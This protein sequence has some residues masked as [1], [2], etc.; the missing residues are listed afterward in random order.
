[1][2]PSEKGWVNN[3]VKYLVEL[4]KSH[5]Y[6]KTAIG[7]FGHLQADEKLYKL[8]QPSGL[9]YGHPIQAPGNYA[10]P[11]SRWE[12]SEKMK[13]ILLDSL[14]NHAVLLRA[15]EIQ[16]DSDFADCLHDSIKEIAQFYEAN[17]L[18]NNKKR[19]SF[20][21]K[22]KKSENE[23]VE[24][25]VTKRLHVNSIWNS[26]F[27]SGFFQNS[28]LFLDVY[29][30]GL[31]L[32]RKDI[33]VDFESFHAHQEKLRMNLL[34]MIAAAAHAN[35]IIEDEE[36]AL[37]TFFIQSARLSK[38]N[39]RRAMNF[40]KTTVNLE[41]IQF[42]TDDPWIIRKYMLE[43]AILTVWA[44]RKVEDNE[45]EFVRLL[46]EK[47][48]FSK[49][50][51]DGSMLA[52]ESFIISNWEQVHFLQKKH[53]LLIIKD[54]FTKRFSEIA[55]KNKKAFVQ[56]IKESKELMNLMH[57]MTREKLSDT[58]KN[59]VRAQL[60]DVLKTLPALVIIALPGT[61]MT[62][63]LLLKLLPKSAF[64]SAFSEID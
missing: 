11:M 25:I 28:L 41:N 60:L 57:K 18:Y 12:N 56:E 3:Y 32:Q 55:N 24:S 51:L 46:A 50:E 22:A 54:T 34:Q 59:I 14:I 44:D 38:E 62:L 15:G 29:Y 31:W 42:D 35:N 17:F 61:F 16:S 48:G 5:H 36:K 49:E 64:P 20:Y 33:V 4:P 8:V 52:I 45:K 63:P 40:L 30:F 26:N 39:E 13:L 10:I 6:K 1:M 7:D 23:I 47:L 21:S 19:F 37:F 2:R 53:D 58:E 43:L 27:W 9:M